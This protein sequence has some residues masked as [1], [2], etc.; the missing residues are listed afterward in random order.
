MSGTALRRVI[1]PDGKPQSLPFYPRDQRSRR[2][3]LGLLDFSAQEMEDLTFEDL[4][5]LEFERLRQAAANLR[6]DRAL[7]EL[8]DQE[9]A[10]ALRLVE[11]HGKKLIPN[12]AGV[13]LLGRQETLRKSIPTHL[14]NFQVLDARG[15]VKVNDLLDGALIKTIQEIET[16]FAARNEERE[17]L[18]GMIRLPIPVIH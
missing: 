10:K 15:D 8:S 1:G 17:T 16:R 5:P 14:V 2:T 9:I 7:L 18:V 6:G 12:V 4:D 13:L 11:S 3:D